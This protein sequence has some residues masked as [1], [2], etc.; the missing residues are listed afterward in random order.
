MLNLIRM[1]WRHPGNRMQD[2][3]FPG[4]IRGTGPGGAMDPCDWFKSDLVINKHEFN[5]VCGHLSD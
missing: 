1:D 2:P 3:S 5:E 4:F